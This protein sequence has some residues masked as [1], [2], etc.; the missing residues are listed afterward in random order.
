M[1]TG[2]TISQIVGYGESFFTM[3]LSESSSVLQSAD[4]R[5]VSCIR[6]D[7]ARPSHK[8]MV[9]FSHYCYYE[10]SVN[11][12]ERGV[13]ARIRYWILDGLIRMSM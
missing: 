8:A 9:E 12:Q 2:F 4:E 10:S 13:L 11:S 3:K 5:L 6:N 7:L 1:M